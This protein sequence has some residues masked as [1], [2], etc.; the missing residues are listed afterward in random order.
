MVKSSVM[1]GALAV[2]DAVLVCPPEPTPKPRSRCNP[3]A[4]SSDCGSVVI[5]NLLRMKP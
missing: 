4:G 2:D 5:K 1:V 3:C